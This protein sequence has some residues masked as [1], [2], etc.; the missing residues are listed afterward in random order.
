M[1]DSHPFHSLSTGGPIPE[2]KLFQ[3]LTLK[4]QGRSHGCGQRARSHNRPSI[5][6]THFLF[7]SHQSD[8][9]FR[10]YSYFEIWPWNIQGQGHEWGH[11][12]SSYIVPSIQLMHFLFVSHQSDQPFLRYGQKR[13][14]AK[15]TVVNRISPKSNQIIIMTRATKLTRLFGSDE[16]FPLYRADK[17][18]F[19]NRRHSQDLGSRSWIGHPV[20]F[21]RPIYSLCQISKV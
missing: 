6:L 9:Q 12:S 10:R 13:K 3:T 1:D 20:H 7:I 21:P 11:R 2:I 18:I 19:A 4:L 14:F 15:I 16:W 5:T 8:Q 17:Q